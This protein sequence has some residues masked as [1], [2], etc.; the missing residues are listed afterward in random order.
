MSCAIANAVL[1]VLEE[2][3]VL[4]H[5]QK[6]GAL[7]IEGGQALMKRHQLIGDVRGEGLFVGQ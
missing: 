2:T 1:D 5:A 3:D 6:L 7:L 4:S